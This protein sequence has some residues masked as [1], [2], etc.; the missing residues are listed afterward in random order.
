MLQR[1]STSGTGPEAATRKS[2]R[3]PAQH[4]LKLRIGGAQLLHQ[5]P[6]MKLRAASQAG[7]DKRNS[8]A[9]ANV[10]GEVH[11]TG[12]GIVLVARQKRIRGGVNGHE[13]ESHSRSEE[14]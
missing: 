5:L 2:T 10:P 4:G 3:H 1:G 6:L 8:D 11:Q 12:R 9:A 14:R 7:G 13:Q